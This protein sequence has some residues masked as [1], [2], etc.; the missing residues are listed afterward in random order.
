VGLAAKFIGRL[1]A[2]LLPRDIIDVL[3]FGILLFCTVGRTQ[4]AV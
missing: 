2:L 4:A 1:S 3:L